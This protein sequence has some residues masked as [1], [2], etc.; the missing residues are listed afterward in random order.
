MATG[1]GLITVNGWQLGQKETNA[2]F[3]EITIYGDG[4]GYANCALI[5]TDYMTGDVW[6]TSLVAPIREVRERADFL[7]RR[8]RRN[9]DGFAGFVGLTKGVPSQSLLF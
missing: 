3:A 9:R 4:Y 6:H 8:V 1:M 2:I 7:L 5:F